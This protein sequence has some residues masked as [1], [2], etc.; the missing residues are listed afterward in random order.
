MYSFIQQRGIESQKLDTLPVKL[1][2]LLLLAFVKEEKFL[3]LQEPDDI[4]DVLSSQLIS[5]LYDESQSIKQIFFLLVDVDF[6]WPLLSRKELD[7]SIVHILKHT[8][9]SFDLV[10][11]AHHSILL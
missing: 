9:I 8:V 2:Y 4:N 5:I 1:K 11:V 7:L 10:L 3:K 6:D